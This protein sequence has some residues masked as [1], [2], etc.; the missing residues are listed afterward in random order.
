MQRVL[1]VV[2]MIIL[3]EKNEDIFLLFAQNIYC[4]VLY[5]VSP[6]NYHLKLM[7]RF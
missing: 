1:K 3:D 2:K 6:R 4:D 7:M 5:I